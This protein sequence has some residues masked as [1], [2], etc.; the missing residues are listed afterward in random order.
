MRQTTNS[1]SA[2]EKTWSS[3]AWALSITSGKIDHPEEL[4][5]FL[6]RKVWLSTINHVN[7][8]R[9]SWLLLV[10]P[11]DEK[12]FVGRVVR[13]TKDSIGAGCS[14]DDAPVICSEVVEFSSEYRCFV[15]YGKI[16]DVRHY[17]GDWAACRGHTRSSSP[18]P[19]AGST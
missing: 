12:C 17:R 19:A 4:T 5:G 7:N 6:G 9:D 11:V 3:A 8:E 2:K 10:K 14:G 15:R 16:L 13:G 18:G 1:R